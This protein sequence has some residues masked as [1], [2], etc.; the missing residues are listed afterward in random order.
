MEGA[1][2]AIPSAQAEGSCDVT[3]SIKN[4]FAVA[5]RIEGVVNDEGEVSTP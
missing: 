4:I 1:H 5:G 3:R 2:L